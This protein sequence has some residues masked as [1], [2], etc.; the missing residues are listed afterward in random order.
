MH[1]GGHAVAAERLLEAAAAKIRINLAGLAFH[2]AFDGRVV[3]QHHFSLRAQPRQRRLELQRFVHRFVHEHLGH[4]FAPGSEHTAAKTACKPFHAGETD[5]VHFARVAVEHLDAGVDQN[6]PD[7]LLGAR[8]EIVVAEDGHDGNP[9]GRGQVFDEGAR[10]LGMPVI[11]EIAGD[12]ERLRD[13]RNLRQ[14]RL[15]RA[16][17]RFAEMQV[18][19]SG[20]AHRSSGSNMRT[21]WHLS[22]LFLRS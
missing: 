6:L 19:R 8:F 1:H 5:A 14:H 7:F 2:G 17:G 12:D 10:L 11:G 9:R 4:L 18:G 13:C 21:F 20:N 15:Q 22:C 3:Q 16:R